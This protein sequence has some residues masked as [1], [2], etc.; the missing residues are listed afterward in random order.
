MS[1]ASHT[2]TH[3]CGHHAPLAL[4]L[5]ATATGG[6]PEREPRARAAPRATRGQAAAAWLRRSSARRRLSDCRKA[7][8]AADLLEEHPSASSS[9]DACAAARRHS[10]AGGHRRH[11]EGDLRAAICHE[12]ARSIA[13][14]RQ[15]WAHGREV[16]AWEGWNSGSRGGTAATDRAWLVGAWRAG[17]LALLHPARPRKDRVLVAPAAPPAGWWC[18]RG[19]AD[20]VKVIFSRK[21]FLKRRGRQHPHGW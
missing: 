11:L 3:A 19:S 15:R 12:G 20:T 16:C 7:V 5:A 4:A 8:S 9:L 2:S 6:L 14:G 13:R 17:A 10:A 18:A 1:R 21:I